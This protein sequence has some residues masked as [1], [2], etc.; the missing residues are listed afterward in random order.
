MVFSTRLDSGRVP[1]RG[2]A[3]RRVYVAQPRPTPGPLPG[4]EHVR[5]TV[6]RRSLHVRLDGR[7]GYRAR[8]C[9]RCIG[10]RPRDGADDRVAPLADHTVWLIRTTRTETGHVFEAGASAP[11]EPVPPT[12]IGS[13]AQRLMAGNPAFEFRTKGMLLERS[14]PTGSSVSLPLQ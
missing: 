13:E 4:K 5:A 2:G 1:R 3:S 12:V 6:D 14:Q 10:R 7:T 11:W 9:H 8:P